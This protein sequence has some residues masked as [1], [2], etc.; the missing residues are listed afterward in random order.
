MAVWAT[1]CLVWVWQFADLEAGKSVHPE[2]RPEPHRAVDYE[3]LKKEEENVGDTVSRLKIRG[4][5]VFN[6]VEFCNRRPDLCIETPDWKR[7]KEERVPVWRTG[8][9]WKEQA[10][11]IIRPLAIWSALTWGGFYLLV[12][13]FSGFASAGDKGQLK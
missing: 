7:W 8:E 11:S 6:T 1:V 3:L 12:W 13:V 5:A 9:Y 4:E 10:N 2:G